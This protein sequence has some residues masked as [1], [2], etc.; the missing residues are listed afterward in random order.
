[1][2]ADALAASGAQR[3]V[4]V[5]PHTAAADARAGILVE[6][7]TA[8]RAPTGAQGVVGDAVVVAPDLSAVRLAER[9]ALLLH[10]P[11]AVVRKAG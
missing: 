11:V 8:V 4:V 1:M 3:L 10:R 9:Y 6:M 5:D 2:V 7:L